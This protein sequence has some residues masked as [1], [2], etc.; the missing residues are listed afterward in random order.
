M[1]Y[2]MLFFIFLVSCAEPKYKSSCLETATVIQ[3]VSMPDGRIYFEAV[4]FCTRWG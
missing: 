4:P 2:L 1:K 3:K